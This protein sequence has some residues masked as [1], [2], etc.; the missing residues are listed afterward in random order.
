LLPAARW[1]LVR[2]M[3]EHEDGGDNSSNRRSTYGLRGAMS[4]KV[5]AF[6]E[7]IEC[8]YV[9]S[10]IALSCNLYAATGLQ[11]RM[12]QFH[13]RQMR[14]CHSGCISSF[15]T[16]LWDILNSKCIVI[17]GNHWDVIA[18]YN[19]NGADRSAGNIGNVTCHLLV[20]SLSEL[21][22]LRIDLGNMGGRSFARS[23]RHKRL[24][25]HNVPSHWAT[26]ISPPLQER[27][28]SDSY[29]TGRTLPL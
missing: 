12:E 3:L 29:V 22:E 9:I 13:R 7:E 14:L 27:T 21:K 19:Q 10:D 11:N 20:S 26:H 24:T 17:W 5:S 8:D 28:R 15:V 23:G 16:V 25:C 2:L 6:N 18:R 1:F 4:L